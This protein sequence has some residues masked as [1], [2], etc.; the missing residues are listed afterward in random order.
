MGTSANVIAGC[1]VATAGVMLLAIGTQ[2]GWPGQ[3]ARAAETPPVA[4]TSSVVEGGGTTLHSVNIAFPRSEHTFPGGAEADAINDNC[5]TCHSAGMVLTQP[6]LS[7]AAWQAEVE[8]M[9]D[10][11]KAPI[12]DDDIRA[13]VDYLADFNPVQ[14][15]TAGRQ[16]DAQHGAMIVA[17]GTANG[18]PACVQ[19]HAFNGVS[20]GTGAFPRLA[21]QS[22]FYL[23]KQLR[24]FASGSRASALMSPMAKALSSD[25]IADVTAYYASIDAPFLPLKTAD[26]ALIE[27]GAQLAK[28]GNA[29][30]GI[31]NCDSC[32]GPRGTGEPPAIPYL[33]GQYAQYI[34]FTLR[35]W[36]QGY[37]KSNPQ[38]MAAIAKKLDDDDIAAVAAYFQ[39][40]RRTPGEP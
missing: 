19:C 18:A 5:L 12:T 35:M 27:R 2:A 36:Q 29:A 6:H 37:R 40:V 30:R 15:E 16:P 25:D 23:A 38:M 28:M 39:Q 3:S 33:H 9:R 17:Q 20:D 13:I 4:L 7:R 1:A 34:A 10:S 11:F 14:A 26:P 32:H 22:A 8:K 21:G 31:Q 24:N